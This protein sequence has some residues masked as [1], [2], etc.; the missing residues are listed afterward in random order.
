M[1]HGFECS[2]VFNFLRPQQQQQQKML[3]VSVTLYLVSRI[4]TSILIEQFSWF[5]I[6]SLLWTPSWL[7]RSTSFKFQ[8]VIS[9]S[10][11][12]F[13]YLL[14]FF[15]WVVGKV[16][17]FMATYIRCIDRFV[18]LLLSIN[19]PIYLPVCLFEQ[20][21]QYCFV[22]IKLIVMIRIGTLT[23]HQVFSN[24]INDS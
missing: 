18:E 14:L 9:I 20:T 4:R 17:R 19:V 23:Y 1:F 3:R 24:V 6:S 15:Y 11:F 21:K 16:P 13:C 5:S 8:S 2:N 10:Y 7:Q 22:H 12:F